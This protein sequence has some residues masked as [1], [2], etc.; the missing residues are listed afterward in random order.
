MWDYWFDEP[1]GGCGPD[2]ASPLH[3]VYAAYMDSPSLQKPPTDLDRTLAHM[4]ELRLLLD[5]V[6]EDTRHLELTTSDQDHHLIKSR[7]QYMALDFYKFDE[8]HGLLVNQL[9]EE[10]GASISHLSPILERV[11]ELMSSMQNL[12]HDVVRPSS[13][14]FGVLDELD[15]D[16][17]PLKCATENSFLVCA[18]LIN[19][20]IDGLLHAMPDMF[21]FAFSKLAPNDI[22]VKLY[23]YESF[24]DRVSSYLKKNPIHCIDFDSVGAAA[25]PIASE[26]IRLGWALQRLV[27]IHQFT[28][29]LQSVPHKMS[30]LWIKL[31]HQRIT[32]YTKH[33]AIELHVLLALYDKMCAAGHT[34]LTDDAIVKDLLAHRDAIGR[35]R[36]MAVLQNGDAGSGQFS[37]A[38]E[39]DIGHGR[40]L[41]LASVASEWARNNATHYRETCK[42]SAQIPDLPA[43]VRRIDFM[44][45]E[46]DAALYRVRAHNAL[47][48]LKIPA[49]AH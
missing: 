49:M 42:G 23:D 1:H 2:C 9:D 41:L 21:C 25:P 15:A 47:E 10:Q 43:P 37:E 3:R 30:Q 17:L 14:L 24:Q 44:A 45:A 46:R 33:M 29:L 16:G 22:S 40:L 11:R 20:F 7:F 32:L 36:D 39:R 18:H 12:R 28:I 5:I 31:Q 48:R 34:S 4:F 6:L 38:V 35:L 26:M 27:D 13:G 19:T 8:L